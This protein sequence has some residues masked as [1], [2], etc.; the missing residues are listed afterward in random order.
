M[1]ATP[2]PRPNSKPSILA[3]AVSLARKG[4]LRSFSRADVAREA[5]LA[6]ATISFHYGSM[7]TLRREVV[8]EAIDK[9]I[10]SILADARAD[11]ASGLIVRMSAELKEKVAE[12]ISR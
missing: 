7:E 2:K 3:A 1:P 9:E 11:R 12:Y 6:K 8:K 4:G 10:L 5:D